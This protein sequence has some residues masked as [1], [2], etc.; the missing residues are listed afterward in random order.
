MSGS[1]KLFE[2]PIYSGG[3]HALTVPFQNWL[4]DIIILAMGVL[5]LKTTA[6]ALR[7]KNG[8]SWFPIKEV[9]YLFAG[10][11]MTI[12]PALAIL[13]AFRDHRAMQVQIDRID[14]A[15]LPHTVDDTAGNHVE[16]VVGHRAG[17]F[18]GAPKD[19]DERDAGNHAG[20]SRETGDGQVH[21][22]RAFDN[23]GAG[24]ECGPAVGHFELRHARA[25]AKW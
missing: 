2:V 15:C 17:R 3:S 25:V 9:A 19:R 6:K 5:S 18:G 14:R 12:I 24:E 13:K 7:E 4:K 16:G 21:A 20:G 10:I 11:F 22:A 8:F 23:L 1:L